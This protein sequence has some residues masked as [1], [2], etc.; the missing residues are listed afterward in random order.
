[1]SLISEIAILRKLKHPNIISLLEVY[2]SD[3]NIHLVL[4]HLTGGELVEKLKVQGH[5]GEK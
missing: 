1:M 2:E 3:N 4:E 5:Y